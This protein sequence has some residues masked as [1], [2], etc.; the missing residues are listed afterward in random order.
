MRFHKLE[1]H[2]REAGDS[3]YADQLRDAEKFYVGLGSRLP[4]GPVV[5][6]D[7]Q[8]LPF[9]ACAFE[10]SIDFGHRVT[11]GPVGDEV[12]LN[13]ASDAL[14]VIFLALSGDGG[15]S[16]VTQIYSEY[17]GSNRAIFGNYWISAGSFGV[18]LSGNDLI[19]RA[20]GVA[21]EQ[22]ILRADDRGILR[23]EQMAAFLLGAFLKVLN[24]VN[25]RTETIEAPAA[26]NKKR[27]RNGKPPIYSY[28]T[29]V[30]RPSAQQRMD[31]G[32]A[33]ESP[34]IHLRRGHIKHRKT[35]DFWWQPCVVGDRT[36][37]VV[38][39]DY[40]AERLLK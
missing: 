31:K 18:R 4:D 8:R 1:E 25:V 17:R 19:Y 14:P 20:H 2:L 34:R 28:K 32:G 5:I 40:R 13:P 35:G 33:H 37:G 22:I 30:L 10:F 23:A 16:F 15:Q 6:D 21:P 24:C 38:M 7:F 11:L 36:R 39:K 12:F 9:S 29:L 3:H 27:T 26:L